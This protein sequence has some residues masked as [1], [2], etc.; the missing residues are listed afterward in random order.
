MLIAKNVEA[1]R[2]V[3][4]FTIPTRKLDELATA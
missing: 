3:A 1:G 4:G 2:L